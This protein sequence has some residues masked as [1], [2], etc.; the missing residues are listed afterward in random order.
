MSCPICYEDTIVNLEKMMCG[1][2]F[3]H[4][5]ICTWLTTHTDC[6]LC[7]YCITNNDTKYTNI[8][9]QPSD[10]VEP[11]QLDYQ[12]RVYRPLRIVGEPLVITQVSISG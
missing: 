9:T 5:C 2:E 6:P 12:E 11:I 8:Y 1:H 10:V 7:R 3:C 4:D